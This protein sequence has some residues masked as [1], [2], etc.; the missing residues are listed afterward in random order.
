MTTGKSWIIA[1]MPLWLLLQLRQW[2]AWVLKQVERRIMELYLLKSCFYHK[3]ILF[4]AYNC[5][6]TYNWDFFA[7]R[8]I[9]LLKAAQRAAAIFYVIDSSSENKLHWTN[10]LRFPRHHFNIYLRSLEC[11]VSDRD[12]TLRET[13]KSFA[14]CFIKEIENEWKRCKPRFLLFLKMSKSFE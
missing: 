2:S 4:I 12:S 6:H 13:I 10:C 8:T 5:A 3:K 9:C 1:S 7:D 14:N 11:F